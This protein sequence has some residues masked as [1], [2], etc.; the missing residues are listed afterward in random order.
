VAQNGPA[1]HQGFNV[2]IN[3]MPG[4]KEDVA[5]VVIALTPMATESKSP[6]RSD[7]SYYKSDVLSAQRRT[8]SLDQTKR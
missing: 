3:Q 7:G 2:T 1:D 8:R 5:V 6:F 4:E